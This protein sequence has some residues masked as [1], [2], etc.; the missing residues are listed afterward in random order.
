[1]PFRISEWY[2]IKYGS[3]EWWIQFMMPHKTESQEECI[4]YIFTAN[5]ALA[6]LGNRGQL[7]SYK[8]EEGRKS[9]ESYTMYFSQF[10]EVGVIPDSFKESSVVYCKDAGALKEIK[11]SG[12]A[13]R[14]KEA[15]ESVCAT[16]DSLRAL[17]EAYG[18]IRKKRNLAIQERNKLRRQRNQL[19]AIP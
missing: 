12:E 1:M 9:A 17:R 8:K 4:Y 14:T 2:K 5:Y 16:A 18:R 19:F 15:A 11:Y 7:K 10:G 6:L 13:S 3:K